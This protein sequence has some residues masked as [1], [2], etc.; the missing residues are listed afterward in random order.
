MKLSVVMAVYNGTKYI[1][2][3]LES[4]YQQTKPVDEVIIIDDCS[5]D[6]SVKIV[7]AFIKKY[8][9]TH[10]Q[11]I[12]NEH[13]LGY[14]QNFKKGLALAQGNIIFL[15]DQDDRWHHDKIEKMVEIMKDKQIMSLASSFNFMN[16]EGQIFKI[17]QK[18]GTA[19]NNLLEQ[20]INQKL[21]K[22]PLKTILKANFSQGCTMALKKELVNEFLI[23]S[24]GKLPHDWELNIISASNQSCYFLDEA[25]IDYRIHDANTI[26]LDSAM[27][28]NV[29]EEK[30][31]R[32]NNRI[33]L[34]K[35]ELDNVNFALQYPLNPEDKAMCQRKR[36]YLENRIQFMHQKQIFKLIKFYVSGC[37]HEFGQTKTF[38]GDVI[39]C[40]KNKEKSNG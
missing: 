21:T 7:K 1:E 27:N 23:K 14:R 22:I 25:L 20:T 33:M 6:D 19:N 38:I 37:Y 35:K 40:I 16:Q 18:K 13:N 12:E 31:N 34:S 28:K 11:I 5:K 17:K 39:N 10:W 2:E 15:C 32:V 29:V 30:T 36:S 26:G 24:T 8:N 3:Q 4:I 9:L